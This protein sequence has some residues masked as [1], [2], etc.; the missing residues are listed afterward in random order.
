MIRETLA[1]LRETLLPVGDLISGDVT[2]SIS[3]GVW[4]FLIVVMIVYWLCAYK[5]YR[6]KKI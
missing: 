3:V 1:I 6:S 5:Q 2:D 4:G